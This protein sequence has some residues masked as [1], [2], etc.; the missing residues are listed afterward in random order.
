[1]EV[2]QPDSAQDR[3]GRHVV[4]P[5]RRGPGVDGHE[6]LIPIRT[7]LRGAGAARRLALWDVEVV[8]GAA[9]ALD[10]GRIGVHAQSVRCSD[11]QGI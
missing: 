7:Y 2:L 5:T 6:Q 3:D 4:Q 10:P 11:S 8:D 9:I 1:M